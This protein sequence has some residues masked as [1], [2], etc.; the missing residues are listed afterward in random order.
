MSGF[1]WTAT[2]LAVVGAALLAF[3]LPAHA[4]FQS[5]LAG[6]RGAAEAR[7]VSAQ[8]FEQLTRGL[9]ANPDILKAEAYQPEFK[10]AIWDYLA[11]LVDEERVQD[12]EAA[13][14]DSIAQALNVRPA[15]LRRPALMSSPRSGASNRISGATSAR[16]R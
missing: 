7:G 10:T 12:G 15:P 4:D 11:G 1:V 14:A 2:R 16:S 5:C 13:M 9:Q 3:A 8:T 6:L